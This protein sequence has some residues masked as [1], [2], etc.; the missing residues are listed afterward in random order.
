MPAK[1]MIAITMGDPGG[2]GPEL[3][4]KYLSRRR[5]G[6]D[7]RVGIVGD[8]AVLKRVAHELRMPLDV[9][10]A[11]AGDP[12]ELPDDDAVVLDLENIALEAVRPGTTCREAGRASFE[13]VDFAVR[14]ALA[15][16]LA[17]VV[18]CPI[19]KGAW[20]SEGIGFPG[21]TELFAHMTSTAAYAMMLHSESLAVSLAT[22]H[23]ALSEVPARL[24]PGR[25]FEVIELTHQTIRRLGEPD[26]L[27]GV[28]G[29]NPHAGEE[30][31]F[32]D[33]EERIIAPAIREAA[34]A[35]IRVEGPLP[36]DTAFIESKLA[37]YD[38]YVCQ[39]HDQGLIPFKMLAFRTGVNV[40]MGLPI[41][42]TSVDHGTA[43]D[44]AWQGKADVDSLEAAVQLATRLAG[45]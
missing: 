24:S 36:P 7:V 27:I 21:H 29:L 14:A 22:T 32:G 17:G 39:Y 35:G 37:R 2:V 33:E 8:A 45:V 15:G 3:C 28:C 11:E 18:T 9:P 30:G 43:F 16:T 38:A 44:I 20:A 40:T 6:D 5:Q 13:Y 4:L 19:H 23:C 41:V 34:A 25:V 26:P 42:R 12:T 10:L 1:P 31:L